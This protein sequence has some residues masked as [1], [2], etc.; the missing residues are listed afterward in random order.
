MSLP[1]RVQVSKHKVSAHD[2]ETLNTLQLGA[3]GPYGSSAIPHF[4]AQPHD[5]SAGRS[6]VA[7]RRPSS[8]S[9]SPVAAFREAAAELGR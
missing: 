9:G 7:G 8:S 6:S 1:L 2:M 5:P 3:S 4:R